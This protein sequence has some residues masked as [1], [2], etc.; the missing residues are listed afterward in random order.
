[1][2]TFRAAAGQALQKFHDDLWNKGIT[3]C[4]P[5]TTTPCAGGCFWMAGNAFHTAVECMVNTQQTDTFN[6]AQD[7]VA[8]FNAAIPDQKNPTWWAMGHNDGQKEQP[9]EYDYWVDDYGWWGNAFIYSH[10]H[11][12]ALG[13]DAD[14]KNDL[15]FYATNCWQALHA[16]WDPT[17][18]VFTDK[19]GFTDTITGGIPN[20]RNSTLLL[21]GRNCVTNECFW[22]L[23]TDLAAATPASGGQNYLDPN[24]NVN[25]FFAQAK[26]QSILFDSDGLVL[27]RFL[28]LPNTDAPNWTWLGDQ[29]LFLA[30]CYFNQYPNGPT[31][32]WADPEEL[33][34]NVIKVRTTADQTVLHEDL[35]PWSQFQLD[36][37]CGKGTFMRNLMY[38]TIDYH[39]NNSGNQSPYDDFIRTNAI[40][41][42]KYLQKGG[43]PFYWNNE[44]GEPTDWGY[45]QR[46]ANAVLYA[47]GLSAINA[48]QVNWAKDNID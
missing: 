26:D 27:E 24:T 19:Y 38:L 22:R 17:P 4:S 20:T 25:N 48:A 1:M 39:K 2:T 13:Y 23:S 18:I 44:P 14:F 5:G 10:L 30:C 8:Y 16:C 35:A 7:A 11:A 41:V 40:A 34:N 45:D 6:L 21:A 3:F 15:L 29:G 28:G 31:Q 46:V 43:C 42:W 12:D 37:A 9:P 33:F 32:A 47:A 36:Y